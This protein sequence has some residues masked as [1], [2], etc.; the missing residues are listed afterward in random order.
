[1][2]QQ[3]EIIQKNAKGHEKWLWNAIP[4]LA[5]MNQIAESLK[6]VVTVFALQIGSDQNIVNAFAIPSF[7]KMDI[8]GFLIQQKKSEHFKFEEVVG[9]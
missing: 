1:M 6:S 9:S 3:I 8:G 5:K 7:S 4:I 2:L